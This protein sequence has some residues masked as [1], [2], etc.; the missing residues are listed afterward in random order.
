[1]V[2]MLYK[3]FWYLQSTVTQSLVRVC[4]CECDSSTAECSATCSKGKKL[5]V[6]VN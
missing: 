1:M 6:V 2:V 3:G 4:A 5:K